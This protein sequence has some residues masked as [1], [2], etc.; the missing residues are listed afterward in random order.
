MG[1]GGRG[2]G[3]ISLFIS[4]YCL[5]LAQYFSKLLSELSIDSVA[6]IK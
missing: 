5:L 4:M 1:G 6:S 2:W 3:I